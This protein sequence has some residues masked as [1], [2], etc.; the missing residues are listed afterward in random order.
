ML[1]VKHKGVTLSMEKVEEWKLQIEH[2]L[3]NSQTQTDKFEF[4][5]SLKQIKKR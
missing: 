1:K 4:L 3:V 5:I 2:I